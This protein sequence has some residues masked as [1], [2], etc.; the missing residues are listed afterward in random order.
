VDEDDTD[1]IDK[2]KSGK[3]EVICCIEGDLGMDKVAKF[4]KFQKLFRV[5]LLKWI[6]SH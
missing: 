1:F 6:L 4:M 2:D 3:F 5:D